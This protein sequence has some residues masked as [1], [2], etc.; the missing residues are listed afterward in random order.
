M[1]KE[2][3]ETHIP[4]SFR[5]PSGFL[6]LRDSILYRQVNKV[7]QPH[8]DHLM[9]SGLAKVLQG[10]KLLIP[11][12]EIAMQAPEPDIAYKI[13]EPELVFFVSYPYE[14]S[15]T[16][17]KDAAL[18]SLQIQKKALEFGMSLKD[19]SAFNVQFHRGA[20]IW[21]DTLSFERY[22]K[23]EPWVAYRQLCQHFLAPLALMSF[24]D[25]RLSQLLRV[26]VDGIP[27]DLASSLLPFRSHFSFGLLSHIHLHARSQKYFATKSRHKRNRKVS[28]KSLLGFIDNLESAVRKLQWNIQDTEWR[29]YYEH[30]NYDNQSFDH[31]KQ[32]VHTFLKETNPKV[33]WDLGA[34]TG[35]FSRI[36]SSMGI[37]TISFDVDPAAVEKNYLEVKRRKETNL[38]PLF[39]DLVNPT[40][41]IGWENKERMSL[42]DRG[43]A[44]TVL[45]LA[46]IHHLAISNNLSL[47]KL[48][49]F[50]A[51]L[52]PF[53]IIEFIPKTD[54]NVQRLLSTREDI[55]SDYTKEAFE[56][57]F[58][59]YFVIQSSE[60]IKGSERTIYLMKR[61]EI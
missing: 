42:L 36:A 9:E 61:R 28:L 52:A 11:H 41:G 16:Q 48:A 7:H 33:I 46:L 34:N 4:A 2:Q 25:V 18:L 32:L 56:L 3:E 35:V 26:Y 45:A 17:L 58:Q 1:N 14:W 27:L 49:S 8:Y 13:I 43:K 10:E 19:C 55:F 20:P 44:D 51:S 54:S 12:Q 53:L 24:R 60:K 39:L 47:L 31:K 15:F 21:I 22:R 50:F 40:P 38:L 57:K 29:D 59:K 37:E 6:F 30:T 5:D 23:G